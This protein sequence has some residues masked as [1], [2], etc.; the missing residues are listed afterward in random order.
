MFAP[1]KKEIKEQI[2]NRIKNEGLPAAQAAREAGVSDKTVYSW[3]ARQAEKEPSILEL[4]RLKRE[5]NGLK[6]LIGLLT[7]EMHK[8][9]K[10]RLP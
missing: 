5:N 9:K 6:H 7:V 8:L 3:L 10:G 2:L 1:I 4:G